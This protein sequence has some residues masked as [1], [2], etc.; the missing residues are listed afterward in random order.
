MARLCRPMRLRLWR[1][2]AGANWSPADAGRFLLRVYGSDQNYR[3][4][5]SSIAAD[6][7]SEKLTNLQGVPSQQIGGAV[8]WA[9]GYG[10]FTVVAGGD[11]LDTRATDNETSV[12]SGIAQPTV[13]I[14]ARQRGD[15]IYGEVLWQPSTLVDCL[16]F[17]AGSLWKFRCEAG[18]QRDIDGASRHSGDGLRSAAGRGEEGWLAACRLLPRAS[19]RFAALR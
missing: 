1:Y 10:R 17:A 12:K 13:S 8:Q 19:G 3:Q 5:F 2:V 11:L 18:E 6:R 15:G 4:S 9:R 14:S 16:L 7:A